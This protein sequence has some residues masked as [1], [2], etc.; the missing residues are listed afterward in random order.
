[1]V[2]ID[3]TTGLAEPELHAEHEEGGVA[4]EVMPP[5][6]NGASAAVDEEIAVAIASA[7]APTIDEPTET[8][9]IDVSTLSGLGIHPLPKI[10]L[11]LVK[12]RVAGRYRSAGAPFQV[13]LRVD[14]DGPRPTMRVSADYYSISVVSI[15]YFG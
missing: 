14:V 4:L 11:P 13:E 5:H 3:P 8:G 7:F 2:D 1:M 12:R 6:E 15:N 9:D 10:P